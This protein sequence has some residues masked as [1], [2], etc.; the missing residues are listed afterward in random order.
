MKF[1]PATKLGK[2]NAAKFKKIN[3]YMMSANCDLSV[4]VFGLKC[5]WMGLSES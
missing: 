2:R 4:S 1:G 3:D 5:F